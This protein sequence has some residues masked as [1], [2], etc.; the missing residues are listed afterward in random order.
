MME[1]PDTLAKEYNVPLWSDAHWKM[2]AESMRYMGE[3]GSRVLH[4]PLI[5]QTNSGNEQSMVRWIKKPDGTY[6]YDFS[7]M[8]KY[9]DYAEKYMGKPKIVAFIAWEIYLATPAREVTDRDPNSEGSWQAARWDLR[10]KGPAVTLLDPETKKLSLGNLP[11]FEDQAA[12]TRAWRPLFIELHRKMAQRGLENTMLLGMASDYS[13]TKPEMQTL[14][15]VSGNL[16]WIIHTHGG[17][18]VE[19]SDKA[20]VAYTAYVWDNVFPRDPS[21]GRY[22]GWARPELIVDFQ[23]FTALNEWPLAS[24]LEFPELQITG[25]QRG[26]G[27]IGADFWPVIKD[28][29]GERRGWVWDQYRASLWHSCNLESHMLDPGPDGPV[30]TSRYEMLRE[31]VQQCEARIAIEKSLLDNH[32]RSELGADLATQCQKLL[33][34]RVWQE[35]KGFSGLQLAGRVYTTYSNYGNIFYYNA[36]GEAGGAWYTGSGWQDRAQ[37]L[38]TLAG[39]VDRQL[40]VQ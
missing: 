39:K 10:G 8:D 4:I 9:L 33:D 3:C 29:R 6:G 13:P 25:K 36:G 19:L 17:S 1:S 22:Y 31:G 23:R 26:V 21:K 32:S 15:N 7:I 12:A 27:R 20:K 30:A 18:H 11:R 14:E 40:G 24:I 35:L 16:P 34:D 28:K 38:Y 5:A 2:I 37:E